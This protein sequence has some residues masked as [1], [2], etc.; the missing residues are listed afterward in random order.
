VERVAPVVAKPIA[1]MAANPKVTKGA[2]ITG[3]AGIIGANYLGDEDDG[4]DEED[5]VAKP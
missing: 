3:G 1:A 2:L 4:F 5:E